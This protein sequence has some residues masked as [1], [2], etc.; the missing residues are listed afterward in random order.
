[1]R[2]VPRLIPITC[3]TANASSHINSY[4]LAATPS[5]FYT[6]FSSWN[7]RQVRFQ[8]TPFDTSYPGPS[9]RETQEFTATSGSDSVL[10]TAEH[11]VTDIENDNDHDI[12]MTT[13]IPHHPLATSLTSQVIYSSS[14]F[15]LA[16][17][18]EKQSIVKFLVSLI[19]KTAQR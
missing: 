15:V 4:Y 16:S 10:P 8:P 19:R 13:T 1:M 5:A 11:G 12:D 2:F 3:P 14:D 6:M 18:E 17:I 9:T 7:P